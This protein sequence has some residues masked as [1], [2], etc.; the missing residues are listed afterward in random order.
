M[1]NGNTFFIAF[2]LIDEI[3][4]LYQKQNDTTYVINFWATTCPP[5]IK[6]MPYFEELNEKYG[7]ISVTM[8]GTDK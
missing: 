8:G 6:E 2:F 4:D 3:S 5:C 7:M 1:L